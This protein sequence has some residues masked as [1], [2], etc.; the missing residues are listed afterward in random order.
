M[1]GREPAGSCRGQRRLATDVEEEAAAE[2][3]TLDS[4]VSEHEREMGKISTEV[5]GEG[6]IK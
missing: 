2:G 4:E 5:K 6:E 3:N 1:A